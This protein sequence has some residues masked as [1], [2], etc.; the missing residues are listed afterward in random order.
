[1]ADRERSCRALLDGRDLTGMILALSR[2]VGET[3]PLITVGALSFIA[4]LP[5]RPDIRVSVSFEPMALRSVYGHADSDVQLGF[6]SPRRISHQCRCSR[7]HPDG[8]D[9]SHERSGDRDTS[10]FSETNPLVNMTPGPNHPCLESR[11]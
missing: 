9:P 11:G 6:P 3:A 8:H 4:F 5:H 2:A 10:A 7:C 1:M